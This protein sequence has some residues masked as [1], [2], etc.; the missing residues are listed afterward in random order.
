MRKGISMNKRLWLVGCLS[1]L[2][3][4]HGYATT[5]E[6]KFNVVTDEVVKSIPRLELFKRQSREEEWGAINA[7][8]GVK[9]SAGDQVKICLNASD[10]GYFRLWLK[11]EQGFPIRLAPN[12]LTKNAPF[13]ASRNK[14]LA[15][16]KGERIC[17]GGD[18]SVFEPMFKIKQGDQGRYSI[19][20]ELESSANKVLGSSFAADLMSG[21][22][23]PHPDIT[24]SIAVDKLKHPS[25]CKG[26]N[27]VASAKNQKPAGERIIGGDNAR[28]EELPWQAALLALD[29]DKPFCGASIL[30]S[31]WAVT[32]S[33]CL[34]TTFANGTRW[35]PK[36]KE[37]LLGY[38]SA[39]VRKLKK[40]KIKRV[41]VHPDWDP[42]KGARA[43]NDIALLELSKPIKLNKK[44][45]IIQLAGDKVASVQGQSCSV[46]S[47]WGK[48]FNGSDAPTAN[49][50]LKVAVP[51]VSKDK[52]A[53]MFDKAGK[54]ILPAKDQ[55]CAGGDGV[56][57]SCQ[58][59]SGGPLAIRSSISGNK[60]TADKVSLV[61]VV[62]WGYKC[63]LKGLP[64][65]YTDI[66]YHSKWISQYVR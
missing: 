18:A 3:Q 54:K 65:V 23:H 31:R 21:K 4:Q 19:W 6:Q 58:G 11:K 55:F 8:S 49:L 36:A 34:E 46:V 47:G 13:S 7:T 30:S 64:G 5:P 66:N 15:V 17:L 48:V 63:A 14:V 59:D 52:C 9:L 45:K 12:R 42:K 50:L 40:V 28:I 20:V 56:H 38:G 25:D 27:L 26:F 51:L 39:Q 61:G 32:A 24:Y 62:S 41:I 53:E 16:S 29:G 10:S 44:S 22:N 2:L 60:H 43:G 33:H 35:Q 1:V 57:D 37:L